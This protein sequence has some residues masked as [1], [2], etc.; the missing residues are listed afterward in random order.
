MRFSLLLGTLVVAAIIG[1]GKEGSQGPA[2]PTGPQGP[3]GPTKRLPSYCNGSLGEVNAG[4]SWTRST[5]C[6]AAADI[7][8]EGWC[9]EPAGVPSGAFLAVTLPVNWDNTSLV[10][11]WSCTWAWQN[12]A[13]QTPF[14][15]DVQIC[16][17]T[18]Q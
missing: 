9:S 8:L 16:C 12:G 18:P 17:A 15:G 14:A 10:A 2:G 7:P 3:A 1:C 13:T 11:G 4:N 6:N 5:S